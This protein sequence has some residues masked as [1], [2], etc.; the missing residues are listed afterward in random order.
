MMR[1][2]FIGFIL[3][4][5]T[6]GD[7]KV[8][9]SSLPAVVQIAA[10]HQAN[11]AMIVGATK[12]VEKGRTTYEVET[13]A[14]GKSRDLSFDK[15][16]NLLTVEQ[17][18]ALD[19]LPTPV[20]EAI[21]RRAAGGTIKKVESINLDNSVSYEATVTTKSGKNAEIAVNSD[22]SPRRD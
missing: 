8:A 10:K 21:Q 14:G 2:C 11:G 4:S 13:K 7:T 3:A 1:L 17:E 20:F 12:E 22:S 18:V 9:F 16:R 15:A 5:I 6:F 19:S